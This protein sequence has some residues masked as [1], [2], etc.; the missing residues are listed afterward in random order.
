MDRSIVAQFLDR[1]NPAFRIF[2]AETH[3]SGVHCISGLK[4]EGKCNTG[5]TASSTAPITAASMRVMPSGSGAK[6]T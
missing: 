5:E 1:F 3:G 6:H 2:G 4:K